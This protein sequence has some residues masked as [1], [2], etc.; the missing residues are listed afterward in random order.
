MKIFFCRV[1]LYILATSSYLLLLLGPYNFCPLFWPS[2]HEMFPWYLSF[3][4]RSLVFPILLFSSVCMHW[5]LRKDVLSLLAVLW[6]SAFKWIYLSF[7]PLPF[8]SLLFSAICKASSDSHFAFL[9]LFF[10]G[11]VLITA[12]STMSWTSVHSFSGTLSD[13]IPWIFMSLPMYNHNEF[14]LFHTLTV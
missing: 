6:N 1:L 7:S 2:L 13:L 4:K 3:L 9:H 8:T 12:F 5:S 14:D 11:L 10:L